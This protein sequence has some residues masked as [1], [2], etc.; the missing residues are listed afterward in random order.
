MRVLFATW[1]QT[2]HYQ[3]L[4]P[5]GWALRAAGHQV[6]VLTHPPF[7][8]TVTGSGLPA[9]PAGPDID[10]T[11]QLRERYAELVGTEA[12]TA[13]A[14]FEQHGSWQDGDLAR[15]E[16]IR[17]QPQNQLGREMLRIVLD[18]CLAMLDDALEFA[19]A[20]QPDLVVYEPTGFLGGI[21]ATVLN[22]PSARV[23][24]APDFSLPM[25]SISQRL[26]RPVLDRFG[27]SDVDITGTVT[28]DP[29]PP[30]MQVQDAVCRTPMRYIGYPGPLPAA[31]AE[32]AA[33]G[34]RQRVCV[35]WGTTIHGV[36]LHDTYL[37]PDVVRALSTVS[38]SDVE[39]VLA[40]LESQLPMFG[41]LPPNVIH[42][43]PVPLRAV[44]PSCDA[45]VHQAGGGT[46]MSSVLSGVP[47]LA[48]PTLQDTMFNARHMAASGAGIHLPAGEVDGAEIARNVRRLLG[49]PGYRAAAVRLRDE[50][51][52]MPTP[53]DVVPDLEKLRS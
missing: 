44:L 18:G 40:V 14:E 30:R 33:R 3:P 2:G 47:Q 12:V 43:G 9:V 45:V 7:A 20:W 16:R 41:E 6:A 35:T 15:R 32:L 36:G 48:V 10:V 11:A 23:L 25:Q 46:T 4:V 8:P 37:A 17:D 42:A 51:L 53:A 5:L 26:F 34:D 19:A 24:W 49:E 31:P 50:A 21:L 13:A 38:S 28:L 29:C 39:I 52:A 1:A 27:L 22:L